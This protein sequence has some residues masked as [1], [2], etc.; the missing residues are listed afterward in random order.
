VSEYR[1]VLVERRWEQRGYE[2]A[3]VV[4]IGL[5]HRCGYVALPESHPWHGVDYDKLGDVDIHGG[6][7]WS[8]EFPDEWV[9]PSLAGRWWIGFDCAHLGDRPD[10]GYRA[11]ALKDLDEEVAERYPSTRQDDRVW[12]VDDVVVETERLVDQVASVAVRGSST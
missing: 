11:Q 7:T 6:L 4:Q 10:P 9:V 5:G 1:D 8:G 2:C 3:A 12:T